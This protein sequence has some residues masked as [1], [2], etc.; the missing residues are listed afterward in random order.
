MKNLII[1]I[2]SWMFL[3]PQTATG[4]DTKKV[5]QE[6]TRNLR[7]MIQ[8]LDY[9]MT[10]S[11]K[12]RSPKQYQDELAVITDLYGKLRLKVPQFKLEE[13]DRKFKELGLESS[14]K[15]IDEFRSTVLEI[16]RVH[17]APSRIPKL[18]EAKSVF[19]EKCAQCHSGTKGFSVVDSHRSPFSY[20]NSTIVGDESA[21]M[22]PFGIEIN[23][24]VLWSLGFY[25][26]AKPFV[27][28]DIRGRSPKD[29]WAR[30]PKETKNKL[31]TSGLSLEFLSATSNANLQAWLEKQGLGRD[32][33]DLLR[34]LRLAAPFVDDLPRK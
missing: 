30:L 13:F 9:A 27:N 28:K 23:N 3:L 6:H 18:A 26:S 22:R 20:Y 7:S 14:A 31:T 34:I 29:L 15:K 11:S 32:N 16:F 1:T 33:L 19:R 24:D 5:R 21:G 10:Y 12:P 2:L 17:Q 8:S 4:R 25:L